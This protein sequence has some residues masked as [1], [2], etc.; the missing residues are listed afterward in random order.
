MRTVT[1]K[2]RIRG[3]GAVNLY[4]RL[5]RTLLASLLL[6]LSACSGGETDGGSTVPLPPATEVNTPTAEGAPREYGLTVL[7]VEHPVSGVIRRHIGDFEAL[8]GAEVDLE[9]VPFYEARQKALVDLGTGTDNYDVM[10][11]MDTWLTE[12][13]SSGNLLDLRRLVNRLPS[14]FDYDWMGDIVPHVN[15]LLGQWRGRQMAIPLMASTQL[16][17]YRQDLFTEQQDAFEAVV[18]RELTVPRT[19]EEF[20]EVARFFTR[21]F[22]PA[23]PTEYGLAVAAE[24]GNSALSLFQTILWGVGGREFSRNWRVTINTQEGLRAME[25]WAEQARYAPPDASAM[26][27]GDMNNVFKQGHAAMQ[28]QWDAFAVELERD[29]A[30]HVRGKVGYALVPG[31]PEPAPVIAGWVL[32]IN[33]NSQRVP[34]AWDFIKWYCGPEFG[35][36]LNREGGQLP[37]FSLYTNPELVERFPHYEA[38]LS[39]FPK[40]QQRGTYSPGGPTLSA[41]TQY[42]RIVGGAAHAAFTGEK[43]PQDAVDDAADELG[44]LLERIGQR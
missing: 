38:A 24:E 30:S 4:D 23:S 39:S 34:L 14:E 7:L 18:G 43:S 37:R 32:V 40:A 44:A 11:L 20:N 6:S 31:E 35:F 12:F 22:N 13:A 17:M 15:V 21:M 9:I 28:I 36:V 1:G 29:A 8:A 42:E 5:V 2:D 26:Y 3:G 25:L 33:A 16:L 41:Q 19:W 27:W 10:M